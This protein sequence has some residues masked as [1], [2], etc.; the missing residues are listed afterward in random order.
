V[1]N[2]YYNVLTVLWTNSA[3]KLTEV[4]DKLQKDTCNFSVSWHWQVF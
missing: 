1:T 4:T 3:S 2:N